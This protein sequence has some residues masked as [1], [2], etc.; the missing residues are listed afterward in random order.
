MT[1][2]FLALAISGL[3]PL[4]L[5]T[6]RLDNVVKFIPFPVLA[7][8]VN[9]FAIQIVWRQWPRTFGLDGSQS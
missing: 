9:G 6:L 2:G 8:F 1:V 3:V 5:G 7:G 4:M